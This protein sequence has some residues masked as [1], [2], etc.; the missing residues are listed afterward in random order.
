MP[1]S[2]QLSVQLT[3]TGR[4]CIVVGGGPVAL[5]R[6][7]SLLQAGAQVVVVAPLLEPGFQEL[8]E[9]NQLQICQ[10]EFEPTDLAP[11]TSA[12]GDHSGLPM[13]VVVATDNSEVNDYV[14]ALCIAAG[15]LVNRADLAQAGDLVFPAIVRW[16]KV[17]LAVS[18]SVGSPALSKW[19]A[20]RVDASLESVLGLSAEEGEQLAQV[21]L[22]V[23]Q[24]LNAAQS[25]SG[26]T[27]RDVT[28]GVPD[29]RS[30]LDESILVLVRTG[31]CAEAKERLLAC[32]SS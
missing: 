29:W 9:T 28:S 16:G 30:A 21:I 13:L 19:V 1:E 14:G 18:N 20:E 10:R 8:T 24:A 31:R 32:L 11:D 15:V 23:R 27:R 22:E 3:V 5:R 25:V 7:R 17:C 2:A 26:K 4:S 6:T 12:P